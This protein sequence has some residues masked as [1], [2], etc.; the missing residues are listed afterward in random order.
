V[1]F[2]P[3]KSDGSK[4]IVV[5]MIAKMND[6]VLNKIRDVLLGNVEQFSAHHQSTNTWMDHTVTVPPSSWMDEE[7]IRT[8][9]M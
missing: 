8:V 2:P 1:S 6:V 4:E 3:T 9:V 5:S 7:D